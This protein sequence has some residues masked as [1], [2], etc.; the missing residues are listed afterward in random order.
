[1]RHSAHAQAPDATAG[2]RRSSPARR[3]S[4]PGGAVT[5]RSAGS[6]SAGRSRNRLVLET[7]R[8]AGRPAHPGVVATLADPAVRPPRA[9]RIRRDVGRTSPMIHRLP[10]VLLLV[11]GLLAVSAPARPGRPSRRQPAAPAYEVDPYWPQELPGD[12]LLGNVVGVATDSRDNVW[13]IHRPNSQRGAEGNASGNRLRAR[14]AAS[15]KRGAAPVK[16]TTGAPRPT[17]ST[18]ITATTSGSGSAA[19]SPTTS[20]RGPRPTTRTS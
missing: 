8:R 10:V 18:S 1:M 7:P 16:G 4:S 11:G 19:D 9:S 3:A 6:A 5:R 14:T 2:S 12:W 15:S 17:A 20:R 13:I